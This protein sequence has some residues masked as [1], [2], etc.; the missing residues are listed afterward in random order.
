M[1]GAATALLVSG[2]TPALA[3]TSQATANAITANLGTAGL[4][5]TGTC[6][7]N[8]SNATGTVTSGPCSPSI[9]LLNGQ[10]VITAGVLTQLATASSAGTS[11]ACAGL[12]GTGGTVSIG[13][14]P[15]CTPIT[16]G[17]GGITLLN[18]AITIDAIMA[19]CSAS[20]TGPTGPNATGSVDIVNLRTGGPVP[21]T[22]FN[23]PA[24]PNTGLNIPGIASLVFNQQ[25][26]TQVP[27]Q[28]KTTALRLTVLGN[29]VDI[30]IG[31][32]SC[33]PNAPEIPAFPAK[34]LP[35][36]AAT[37]AVVGAGAGVFFVRR[38]RHA[39]VGSVA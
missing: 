4:L 24:A 37:L 38:R 12:L 34:G 8:A 13:T 15:P 9:A 18:G 32:V 14:N 16:P 21:V 36:A 11:A 31:N 29:V 22:L 28:F 27:G 30:S 5:N 6:T 35:V 17:T 10:T 23:G 7:A 39:A 25:P 3:D 2:A 20:S 19:R 26:A 33:G 1:M